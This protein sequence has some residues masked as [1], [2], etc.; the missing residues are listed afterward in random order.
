MPE[1]GWASW[2]PLCETDDHVDEL[3]LGSIVAIP[4]D[5][6][7]TQPEWDIDSGLDSWYFFAFAYYRSA[8]KYV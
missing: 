3:F 7:D 6:L 1:K 4:H 2:P 5:F 8:S